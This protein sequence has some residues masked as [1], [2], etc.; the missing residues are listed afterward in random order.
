MDTPF[1]R[2][3]FNLHIWQR[4]YSYNFEQSCRPDVLACRTKF[5]F[6]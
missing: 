1:V 6:R 3:N 4:K 2:G 5:Y